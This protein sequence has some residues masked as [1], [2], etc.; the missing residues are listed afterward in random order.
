MQ[1]KSEMVW[2]NSGMMGGITNEHVKSAV[3]PVLDH[4]V[5]NGWEL[6]SQSICVSNVVGIH[7]VFIKE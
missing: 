1:L 5:A 7:M 4:Y 6:H 2:S 3:Q